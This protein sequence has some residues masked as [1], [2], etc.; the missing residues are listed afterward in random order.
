[1]KD[2]EIQDY[3]DKNMF[4]EDGTPM[5]DVQCFYEGA[6]WM[7]DYL[8]QK[9]LNPYPKRE[10]FAKKSPNIGFYLSEHQFALEEW[11]L[12]AEVKIK[13]LEYYKNSTVGLY[14]TDKPDLVKDDKN[15]MFILTE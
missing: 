3:I 10:D 1:M 4:H 9:T 12:K 5:I 15:I 11:A 7:R 2:Q 6:K 8:I 14:A 13:E